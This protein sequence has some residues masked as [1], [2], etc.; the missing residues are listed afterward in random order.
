MV[1]RFIIRIHLEGCII[2]FS[3][4]MRVIYAWP[5]AGDTNNPKHTMH[6]TRQLP[7]EYEC[8]LIE[9]KKLISTHGTERHHIV[10][11]FAKNTRTAQKGGASRAYAEHIFNV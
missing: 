6:A 1:V 9:K 5:Y 11:S 3:F 8:R 7:G 10:H 2:M 4:R